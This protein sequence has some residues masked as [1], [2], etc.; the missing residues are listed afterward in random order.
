MRRRYKA[1]ACSTSCSTEVSGQGEGSSGCWELLV[2]TSWP[3]LLLATCCRCLGWGVDQMTSITTII[4]VKGFVVTLDL[5]EGLEYKN[6]IFLHETWGQFMKTWF[7][8]VLK[9]SKFSRSQC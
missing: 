7:S 5:E 2:V 3:G 9:I 4:S 8:L 1:T 6:V